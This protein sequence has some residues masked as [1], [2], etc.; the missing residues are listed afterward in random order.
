MTH[1]SQVDSC[2][3]GRCGA[4]RRYL[5]Q[6]FVTWAKIATETRQVPHGLRRTGNTAR[7][8][9]A[10]EHNLLSPVYTRSCN[11]MRRVNTWTVYFVL[12]FFSPSLSFAGRLQRRALIAALRTPPRCVTNVPPGTSSNRS[13]QAYPES[14]VLW[15]HC[16]PLPHLVDH[17]ARSLALRL[18]MPLSASI[19][20]LDNPEV[21]RTPLLSASVDSLDNP[22]VSDDE[23]E[24]V[25]DAEY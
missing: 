8:K 15:R 16:T 2:Y 22:E 20:S 9:K 4:L 12:L 3:R 13:E 1:L 11:D 14:R 24:S 17:A 19:D 18:D 23:S 7:I 10:F 21:W 5:E 25:Y 6:H